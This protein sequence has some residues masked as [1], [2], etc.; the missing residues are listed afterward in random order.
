[1]PVKQF[2][3]AGPM[4]LNNWTPEELQQLR[5]AATKPGAKIKYIVFIQ[6]KG[7]EGTPHLQIYA[8]A[9]NVMS[10][11]AWHTELGDR[12]ANI[13][14]TDNPA[15]ARSYCMGYQ[16]GQPKDGSD[17]STVEE[18]GKKPNQGKGA[19][20]DIHSAV[21]E[22][23]ET[24]LKECILTGS[25]HLNT[26]AQ[27]HGFFNLVDSTFQSQRVF[28]RGREEHNEYLETRERQPWEY[29]LK[30]IVEEDN[31][32]RT[33]HWFFDPQ[34][35][36]G[37]TVNAKDLYYNHGAFYSTG[38]KAVDIAHA[39]NYEPIVVFNLVASADETTMTYL[40]KVLEEFKDGIFSSGKYQS[41]TKAF[42]IPKV[43]VFSNNLPNMSKMKKNRL[44]VYD[45]IQLNAVE[46][47]SAAP[48]LFPIFE[49]K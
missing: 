31:D 33:I 13:V 24:P 23:R 5:T 30:E 39:Y 6:E 28:K 25:D 19:R 20:N 42:P 47:P 45:I 32:K 49:E 44:A 3:S 4:T 34:G 41:Q 15:A 37:K 43:I 8:Q 21:E 36:T 17:L 12:V 40:Y 10:V 22:L 35:E 2:R 18:Y 38:G 29:K 26:Y 9:F 14:P 48:A 7:A 46:Q 16:G 1:M 11:K 27:Y